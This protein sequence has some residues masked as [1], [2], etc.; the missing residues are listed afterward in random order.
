[1]LNSQALSRFPWQFGKPVE[2]VGLGE[3]L[4]L[5]HDTPELFQCCKGAPDGDK[6]KH[7]PRIII[8]IR[9]IGGEEAA[10]VFLRNFKIMPQE[11]IN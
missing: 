6:E 8:K 9:I 5:S 11:K 10:G 2:G 1:M 4:A 3:G 7:A